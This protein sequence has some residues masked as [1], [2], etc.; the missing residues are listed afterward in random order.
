M[1]AGVGW[2]VSSGTRRAP[3]SQTRKL[4]ALGSLFSHAVA[5]SSELFISVFVVV[6]VPAFFAP[7]RSTPCKLFLPIGALKNESNGCP[8]VERPCNG[9][10]RWLEVLL[11]TPCKLFLP[12]GALK[13]EPNGRPA[14][15]WR[16]NGGGTTVERRWLGCSWLECGV[17][18]GR[19]GRVS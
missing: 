12:I 15:E 18:C 6:V 17:W 16:W 4:G 8:A 19:G 13:N 3:C 2:R 10:W 9:Q 1:I 7:L 14:V 11:S 5:G